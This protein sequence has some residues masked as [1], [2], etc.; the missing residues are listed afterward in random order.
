M[1]TNGLIE[2]KI[3]TR[4]DQVK[5]KTVCPVL[6]EMLLSTYDINNNQTPFVSSATCLK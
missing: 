4:M 2:P 5:I 1:Y 3:P 6:L